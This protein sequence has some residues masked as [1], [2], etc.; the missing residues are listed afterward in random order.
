[1]VTRNSTFQAVAYDAGLAR[2]SATFA[3]SNGHCLGIEA[4]ECCAVG[5]PFSSGS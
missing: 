2:S 1:M 4:G 5:I 3:P